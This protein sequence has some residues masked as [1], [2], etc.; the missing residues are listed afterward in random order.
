M[1]EKTTTFFWAGWQCVEEQD[2][3]TGATEI[4]YVWGAGY[5]DEL[6]QVERTAAHPL[7]AARLWVHCN[8]RFDVVA[9]TDASGAVVERRRYDDFGNVEF[10]DGAGAVAQ[11]SPSGLD[12]GFQGRRL[13]RESGLMYFRHRYYDPELGRFVQRDP[14]WDAG[15]VGGWY[16]YSGNGVL[17]QRERDCVGWILT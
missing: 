12:Y 9:V 8:V 4:T 14:V 3:A 11:A 6:C 13:D 2:A 1:L 16:S 10:R 7:G 15:N 17:V 5:V